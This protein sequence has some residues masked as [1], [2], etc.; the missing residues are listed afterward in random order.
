MS[1]MTLIMAYFMIAIVTIVLILS[2]TNSMYLALLTS[3]L[4]LYGWLIID[5]LDNER[6]I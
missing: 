1:R 6:N 5:L 4:Y 3:I 2:E